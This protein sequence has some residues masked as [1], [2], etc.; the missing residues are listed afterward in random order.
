[1]LALSALVLLFS[2][3]IGGLFFFGDCKGLGGVG[4]K[5]QA[6]FLHFEIF[7]F[8]PSLL[9]YHLLAYWRQVGSR[10]ILLEHRHS[11]FFGASI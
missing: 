1:M 9:F 2:I 3:V 5:L 7:V 4:L 6:A 11:W 10:L 8:G